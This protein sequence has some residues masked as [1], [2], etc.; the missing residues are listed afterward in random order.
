MSNKPGGQNKRG[1]KRF[2]FKLTKKGQNKFGVKIFE[3]TLII[4][5]SL[6]DVREQLL[7]RKKKAFLYFKIVHAV[8]ISH[9]DLFL[10]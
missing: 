8:K 5:L 2:F 3:K 4:L 6:F 1:G 10:N 7:I 9:N